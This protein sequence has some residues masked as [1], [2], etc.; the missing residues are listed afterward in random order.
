MVTGITPSHHTDAVIYAQS[1]SG[2]WRDELVKLKDG[3]D[4]LKKQRAAYELNARRIVGKYYLGN[5]PAQ[6][7]LQHITATSNPALI[8]RAGTGLVS[9]D[10]PNGRYEVAVDIRDDKTKHGPMWIELNGVEYSDVFEVPAG[11]PIH[12]TMETS[13]VR[14]KLNILFD[15]ATSADWYANSIIVTRI[16][17]AI[18]HVPV[19][20][21]VLKQDLNLR[22]TVTGADTI[23]NVRVLIGDA[24]HGFT[25][26]EMKADGPLY[27][28]NIPAVRLG[29][30]TA[31]FLQATDVSGRLS[32]FPENGSTAPIAIQVTGDDQPPTLRQVPIPSAE[33]LHPLRIRAS[34]QDP[35]GIKWVHLLYR[36][37]SEHQDLT[38][39]NMLP[40]GSGNEYEASIP[41]IDIDPH[42][43]LMYFFEVMDNDGNGKI[44]PDMDKETPYT[45]V[46]VTQPATN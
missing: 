13:V 33:P 24:T 43:D 40:N 11:T 23:K 20:R 21:V 28:L 30:N 46:K 34:V 35:S 17:P 12:R 6:P 26:I 36:G 15:H 3:L 31:Y 10:L 2:H 5:T 19:Q 44:Y 14:G 39:L 22:A 16:D 9:I 29:P 41:G 45:I 27:A 4:A 32:T 7:G 25:S 18:A 8:Q 38:V 42:F 37:V 1:L